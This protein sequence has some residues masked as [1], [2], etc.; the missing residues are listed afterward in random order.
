LFFDGD[1][2]EVFNHHLCFTLE[3]F[4]ELI[5]RARDLGK[6][7]PIILWDDAAVFMGKYRWTEESVQE[8]SEF[9]TG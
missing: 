4:G 7:N 3:Q 9:F 2:D 8:F 5:S 1:W 6:R